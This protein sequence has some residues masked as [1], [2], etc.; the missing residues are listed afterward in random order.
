MSNFEIFESLGD[1]SR[2]LSARPVNA[3]FKCKKVLPSQGAEENNWYGTPNY[4]TADKLLLNGDKENAAKIQTTLKARLRLNGGG[5]A[6]QNTI[7]NSVQ[8]FALNMGRLMSGHPENML[9]IRRTMRDSSKVVTIV[10]NCGCCGS[11]T[12]EDKI[13]AG[14]KALEAVCRLEKAGYRC[15]LYVGTIND[16]GHN[17]HSV[18]VKVKDSGK[19]LDVARLAYTFV[20]PS[21]HRRHMFAWRERAAQYKDSQMGRS[22][23]GSVAENCLRQNEQFS[24]AIYIDFDSAQEKNFEELIKNRL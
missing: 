14:I 6:P 4:Q 10:Y 3:L 11:Y 20:N 15:N 16:D 17:Y 21:F 1:F 2:A 24:G 5:R 7:Y 9:N 18:F 8:G 13:N 19:M 12:A 23:L 22:V